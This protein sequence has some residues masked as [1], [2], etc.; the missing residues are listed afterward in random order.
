M[1]GMPRMSKKAIQIAKNVLGKPQNEEQTRD[2]VAKRKRNI[3]VYE[4][5]LI[6]K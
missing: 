3:V 6:S 1:P 2:K 5:V 4:D